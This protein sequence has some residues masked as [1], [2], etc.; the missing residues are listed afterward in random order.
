MAEVH[1]CFT[2]DRAGA[3]GGPRVLRAGHGVE[4]HRGR[5]ASTSTATCRS[6]PTAASS[7]FGHPVGASGL[8]MMFEAWLQ[9]RGEAP[10][11]RTD[12]VDRRRPQPR[13]HPQPRRLPRRDGVVHLDPR[14]HPGLTEPAGRRTPSRVVNAG[15]SSDANRRHAWTH[16][17]GRRARGRSLD[18]R[19]GG[20]RRR[21][22]AVPAGRRSTPA[23]LLVGVDAEAHLADELMGEH[24]V[25]GVDPAEATV[26]E[27]LL[28]A[29]ALED[30]GSAGEVEARCR[31]RSTPGSRRRT[32]STRSSA[33]T[34]CRGRR[35]SPSRRRCGRGR[36]RSPRAGCASRRCG[37]G[38]RGGTPSTG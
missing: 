22:H 38:P 12:L 3:H 32:W 5:R 15:A 24:R 1:D 19:S 25:A 34:P 16:P 30:A 33:A 23:G 36:R 11:D 4:G 20:S 27:Q 6:T 2:P 37:A 26:P 18:D 10:E 29:A 31:R 14:R 35:R 21:D 28:E 9:L 17:I 8:R 7:R 13:P